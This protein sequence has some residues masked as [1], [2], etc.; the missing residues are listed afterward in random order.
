MEK[1]K[2]IEEISYWRELLSKYKEFSSFKEGSDNSN[3]FKQEWGVVS[4]VITKKLQDLIKKND[5]S[6]N[7]IA[8]LAWGISLSSPGT[9]L[10]PC[11]KLL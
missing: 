7:T 2:K 8:E 9:A 5:I 4:E 10:V 3:L 1:Y 11:L 6:L